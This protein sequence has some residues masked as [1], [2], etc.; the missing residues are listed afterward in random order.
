MPR[1]NVVSFNNAHAGRGGAPLNRGEF[2]SGEAALAR[3]KQLVD[4]ALEQLGAVSSPH[5]LMMQY[6]RRGSEVPT[7]Y[8]EPGIAFHAYRYAREKANAVFA[9]PT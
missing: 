5:E 3:A 1:Y 4:Q 2:D 9:A 7:I 6:A 8:G